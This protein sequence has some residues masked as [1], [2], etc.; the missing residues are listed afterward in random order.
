MNGDDI[1]ELLKDESLNIPEEAF[2]PAE[3][4]RREQKDGEKGHKEKKK[5]PHKKTSEMTDAE[6]REY[7]A[8]KA[9]KK[10]ARRSIFTALLTTFLIIIAILAIENRDV[11]TKS[12]LRR[13]FSFGRGSGT[14]EAFTYES[15]SKQSFHM[16]GDKLAVIS[17]S[18]M[19]LLGANGATVFRQASPFDSPAVTGNEKQALFYGIGAEYIFTADSD[20]SSRQMST[21]GKI[22]SAFISENGYIAVATEQTGYKALVTVY[23]PDL[24]A[25]YEWWSGTG[26]VLDACLT[27][28][29]RYLAVL[30][31]S[32][33]GSAVKFLDT[34]TGD[35]CSEQSFPGELF[36]ELKATKSS[37]GVTALGD[38]EVV[39]IPMTGSIR[40]YSY[41]GKYLSDFVMGEDFTVLCLSETRAAGEVEIISL[42]EN[43]TETGRVGYNETLVDISAGDGKILVMGAGSLT[44]M[45]KKCEETER[46]DR[47]MTASSVILTD[48]GDVLLLHSYYASLFYFD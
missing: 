26:Y 25:V 15:G 44:L 7:L 2:A 39:Y 43:L 30:T 5:L 18:S 37:A 27:G 20:G 3:E 13:V 32:D 11:F 31:I 34:R 35:L 4:P 8:D 14:Y 9:R 16:C 33:A 10:T 29:D 48:A 46:S 22:L 12:N 17:S 41:E 28:G 45:N 1:E 40:S 21:N 38:E 6:L 36:I 47:L 42:G 19:Q 23:N 24:T